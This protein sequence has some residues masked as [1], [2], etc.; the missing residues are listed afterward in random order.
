M[1]DREKV[2]IWYDDVLSK[3]SRNMFDHIQLSQEELFRSSEFLN[4]SHQINYTLAH[5]YL[6]W[7][8]SRYLLIDPSD[9]ILKKSSFGKPYICQTQNKKNIKFSLSHSDNLVLI[10]LGIQN[11]LGVDIERVKPIKELNNLAKHCFTI[12]E[13][14]EFLSTSHD[15]KT[16]TFYHG[17]TKKEAYLKAL[18]VGL[19]KEIQSFTI[20]ILAQGM[21]SV[22]DNDDLKK[23]GDW[24]VMALQPF[25]SS[26][27]IGA[28]AISNKIKSIQL[29]RNDPNFSGIEI[30]SP[31][32]SVNL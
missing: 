6:R 24:K 12:H 7:V 25:L 26:G 19:N 32:N 23:R 21:V 4:E 1:I 13:I 18:G 11:E 29:M 22:F 27:N 3:N 5:Q 17:W 20:P 28:L 10:G 31:M 2:I 14:N 30:L 16:M 9:I 15:Q 8:L